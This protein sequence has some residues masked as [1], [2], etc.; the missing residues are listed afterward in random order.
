MDRL[1]RVLAD[2]GVS[3]TWN[4]LAD[5]LWLA[6]HMKAVKPEGTVDSG[7]TTVDRA[8]DR[9]SAAASGELAPPVPI[10]ADQSIGSLSSTDVS[11]DA[12][13]DTPVSVEP[14][15]PVHARANVAPPSGIVAATAIAAPAAY[16]LRH[17][18]SIAR[19][20]RPIAR[21]VP[22]RSVFTLDEAATADQI[23]D[24]RVWT[25]VLRPVRER[26]MRLVLF[27]DSSSSLRFWREVIREFVAVLERLGA[28]ANVSVLS[29]QDCL[30]GRAQVPVSVGSPS[31]LLFVTDGV[32]EIWQTDDLTRQISRWAER[33]TTAVVT[34]L[35]QRMWSAT[36]IRTVPATITSTLFAEPNGRWVTMVKRGVHAVAPPVPVLELRPSSL[37]TFA[38]LVRGT[39]APVRLPV[40]QDR[41]NRP[42]QRRPVRPA[43][44]LVET[45]MSVAS[46]TAAALAR[47]L[48]AVPLS[49]PIMRV[50]QAAMLPSSETVHLAEFM[51]SGLIY[52]YRPAPA[53][54]AGVP[55]YDFRPGV[56]ELLLD[57][58]DRSDAARILLK[59]SRFMTDRFGQPT[60]FAALLANPEGTPLPTFGPGST[61]IAE[62]TG[63]VLRPAGR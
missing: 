56:R 49:L 38:A 34:L 24:R 46:P 25:P 10:A 15:V 52:R 43:A 63:T 1:V 54:S 3:A 18:L 41:A 26:G 50:V 4:E 13:P 62:V 30:S 23:A 7:P 37:A 58:T 48:S 40:L 39:G 17:Q 32:A 2:A 29:L 55:E 44:E 61:A 6:H 27:V 35:P 31:L 20:L 16:A 28:F 14:S 59:V 60:D 8:G 19:A 51:L 57:Q 42:I 5:A 12:Q 22:S 53:T 47:H 9:P 21:T 33:H 45:F 11:G 36:A